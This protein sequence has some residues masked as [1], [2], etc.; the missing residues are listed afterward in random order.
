MSN[1]SQHGQHQGHDERK[2]GQHGGSFK[3][4]EEK[5]REAGRKGSEQSH[6]GHREKE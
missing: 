4:D 3:T 2:G 6:G 1:Q 5:A